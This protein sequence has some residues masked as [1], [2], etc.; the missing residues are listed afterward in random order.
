MT[1]CRICGRKTYYPICPECA[2]NEEK[3]L[4]DKLSK[5]DKKMQTN[6][7]GMVNKNL[8]FPTLSPMFFWSVSAFIL[9]QLTA[10]MFNALIDIY[11]LK[12]LPFL[13]F[14][15][16]GALVF[17]FWSEIPQE[18][19]QN[20]IENVDLKYNNYA[21]KRHRR[22]YLRLLKKPYNNWHT[23]DRIIVSFKSMES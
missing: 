22:K 15:T 1:R 4:L 19:I 2:T 18:N 5:I 20:G 3:Q 17:Y 23:D 8:R 14:P 12:F 11:L 6:K 13:L 9:L 16:I 21:I 10:F 7:K